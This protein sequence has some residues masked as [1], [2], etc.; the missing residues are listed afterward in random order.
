MEELKRLR[1]RDIREVEVINSPGA[2]FD[3]SVNA[4]VRI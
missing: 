2:A 4:V 3:A 1:S